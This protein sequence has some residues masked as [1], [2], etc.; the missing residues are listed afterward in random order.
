MKTT[1][2][3]HFPHDI[4]ITAA[5]G[6]DRLLAF[7]R[8]TFGD[9]QMNA[10]AGGSGDSGGAGGE[11]GG[12]G[13][14]GGESGSGAGGAEGES[15]ESGDG[16]KGL[17]S[18]LS[19]ERAAAKKANADLAASQARV[20]ELEEAGQSEEQ[21]R[22]AATE[23]LQSENTTLTSKL[24]KSEATLEK[25]RVA[26]AKGI[27]LQAAE[28]LNGSTREEIEVDADDLLT[29]LGGAQ[30]QDER[31]GDPGQGPRGGGKESTYEQGAQRAR[32]RFGSGNQQ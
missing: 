26:A 28:R 8:R 22:E 9:A 21:K 14:T 20:R 5:G 24:G 4:D 13:D 2:A 18:A 7:H 11:S 3:K 6:I 29:I 12:S 16:D 1:T 25:Y 30:R 32:N 31:R 10:N 19:A 15:S 17:K 23:R 27:D